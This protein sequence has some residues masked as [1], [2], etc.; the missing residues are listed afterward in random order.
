[1]SGV[2]TSGGRTSD[3]RRVSGVGV[4]FFFCGVAILSAP[5][6]GSE[7]GAWRSIY[8]EF[9]FFAVIVKSKNFSP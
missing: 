9:P 3:K 2:K 5:S 4:V 7:S 6:L 8:L 1:M